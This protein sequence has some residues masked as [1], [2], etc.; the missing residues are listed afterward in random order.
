MKKSIK[1]FGIGIAVLVIG[2]IAAYFFLYKDYPYYKTMRAVRVTSF[3][4]DKIAVSA[5]VICFNP[6][7]IGCRLASCDFEVFA[8][9]IKV[10][11]VKQTLGTN[12]GPDTEFTIPLK[13]SFNPIKIFKP[14]ELL[15]AAISG[16]KS[17]SIDM[18][19]L[20][21]VS[22]GLAGQ[23]IP[24]AVDYSESIPLTN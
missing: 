15:G 2:A 11:E 16:L 1:I 5:D 23:D 3:T 19:Y 9:G 6:N 22:V 24:I 10:S 13:I 20:G 14:T 18:R 8:N 4:K 12:V 7:K 17:K 21:S